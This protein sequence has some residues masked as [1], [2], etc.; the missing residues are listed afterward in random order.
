MHWMNRRGKL[1]QCDV[2]SKPELEEYYDARLRIGQ[3]VLWANACHACWH[4]FGMGTLGA[5]LGQFYVHD[6]AH[7]VKVRG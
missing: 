6:G 7:Y 4:K 5:G 1:Q 2:C 3:R